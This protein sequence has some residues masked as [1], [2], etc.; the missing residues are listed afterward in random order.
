VGSLTW[1]HGG[2]AYID[3]QSVIYTVEQHPVYAPLLDSFWQAVQSKS[4][5]VAT[6]EL[7]VMESLVGPL[8]RS[9]SAL[10]TKFD[11]FFHAPEVK[12]VPIGRDILRAAARLRATTPKLRTPDAI[13]AATAQ[14]LGVALF[15]T[16][17]PDFRLVSGLPLTLLDALRSTP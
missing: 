4:V 8:K 14:A 17:D 6:S 9:D 15:V 10:L 5:C 16:N 3:T 12:L 2:L 11:Q 7:T 13:H 1:P